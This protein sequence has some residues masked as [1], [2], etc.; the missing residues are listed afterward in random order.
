MSHA[1]LCAPYDAH[2]NTVRK[3]RTR[4]TARTQLG[5][6]G[7]SVYA[8]RCCYVARCGRGDGPWHIVL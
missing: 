5:G 7:F 4:S 2:V 6:C 1:R 3:L 8:I